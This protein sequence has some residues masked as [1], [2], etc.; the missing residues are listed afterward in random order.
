METVLQ[1][2]VDEF[3]EWYE[4]QVKEVPVE[5]REEFGEFHSDEYHSLAQTDPTLFRSLTM[6]SIY[7]CLEKSLK[8]LCLLLQANLTPTEK[9]LPKKI[10]LQD[11]RNFF[12]NHTIVERRFFDESS[13]WFLLNSVYRE[14]RNA[15]A[16][17]QGQLEEDKHS[18]LKE[19][20]EKLSCS[21]D[22][23]FLK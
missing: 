4:L 15:F 22:K 20:I 14:I 18:K 21:V 10:Y 13:D 23:D 1:N 7:T 5:V 12:I 9:L 16:H 6:L 19:S 8:K 11:C 17:N 3:N 2:Q